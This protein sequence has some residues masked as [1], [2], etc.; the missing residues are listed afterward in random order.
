M[1]RLWTD[2]VASTQSTA[3]LLSSI[4]LFLVSF[5]HCKIT[6]LNSA[7]RIR[8]APGGRLLVKGAAHIIEMKVNFE[9]G[10]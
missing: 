1:C 3:T 4:L 7:I 8:F 6:L 5:S 10:S 2:S 9:G